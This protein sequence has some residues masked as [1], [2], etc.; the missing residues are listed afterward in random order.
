MSA[1]QLLSGLREN[2]N[3]K[4]TPIATPSH[5]ILLTGGPSF[6]AL[7][8]AFPPYWQIVTVCNWFIYV[9][10]KIRFFQRVCR[11]HNYLPPRK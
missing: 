8:Y 3:S 11:Y 4:R 7:K 5:L 10:E 9:L 6:S 1:K 2:R